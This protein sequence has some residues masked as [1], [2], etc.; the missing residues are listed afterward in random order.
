MPWRPLLLLVVTACVFAPSLGNDFT[1][2][3]DEVYLTQ[4]PFVQ[5]LSWRNLA[6]LF[7]RTISGNYNPLVFVT[8]ASEHA[9]VGLWPPLYHLDNLIL[10]LVCAFL[11]F[12]LLGRLGFS[13]SASLVA[14]LW[15]AIHPMRVESV[16]WVAERK[17]LL[18]ATFYLVALICYVGFL[19]GEST[20]RRAA[21]RVTA[22]LV[23]AL[24]SK[25]QAVSLPLALVVLDLYFGRPASWGGRAAVGVQTGGPPG[26]GTCAR[27][28]AAV[29]CAARST[30]DRVRSR[31]RDPWRE[32][33]AAVARSRAG[34]RNHRTRANLDD[35]GNDPRGRVTCR[36]GA[37]LAPPGLRSKAGSDDRI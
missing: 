25:V 10:H 36:G 32:Q 16:A 19:R 20:W 31:D 4:N 34:A 27:A 9:L 35:R 12:R 6:A 33:R 24:L 3:D 21:G 29:A 30:T 13:S 23:L 15:F 11:V 37:C 5:N 1:N 28:H 14:A 7:T 17:D 2:W 18:Y 22:L 26:E 8:F